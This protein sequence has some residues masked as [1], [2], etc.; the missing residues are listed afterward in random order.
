[1]LRGTLPRMG[2]RLGTVYRIIADA[3]STV[4]ED[5][6]RCGAPRSHDAAKSAYNGREI[7]RA[8]RGR[9]MRTTAYTPDEIPCEP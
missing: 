6:S 2:I 7:F 9:V 1:M 8:L 4:D 3:V 5:A